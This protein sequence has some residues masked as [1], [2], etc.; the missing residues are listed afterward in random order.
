[1]ISVSPERADA[2]AVLRELVNSLTA[3][4]AYIE[5]MRYARGEMPPEEVT[6]TLDKIAA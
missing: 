5:A 6:A 2:T 1:M 4:S 3:A